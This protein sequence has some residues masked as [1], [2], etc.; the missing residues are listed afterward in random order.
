M[1]PIPA[2]L[3]ILTAHNLPCEWYVSSDPGR[4]IYED[5]HQVVVV[6][7]EPEPSD[8]LTIIMW[9]PPAP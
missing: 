7:H 3:A 8:Q 4:I 2:Y 1:E 6:P 9:L 5:P